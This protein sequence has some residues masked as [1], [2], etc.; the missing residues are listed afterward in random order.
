MQIL[1]QTERRNSK[2]PGGNGKLNFDA[3]VGT[4]LL[5]WLK[6]IIGH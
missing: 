3:S 1:L 6:I 5:N 4:A 2:D